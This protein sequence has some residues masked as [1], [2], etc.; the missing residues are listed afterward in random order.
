MIIQGRMIAMCWGNQNRSELRDTE[1][2][3]NEIE[4]MT[5]GRDHREEF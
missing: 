5:D 1:S 4:G 2:Q 3:E